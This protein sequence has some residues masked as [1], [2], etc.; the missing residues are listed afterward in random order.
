MHVS[1][2]TAMLRRR[3]TH[4]LY[5]NPW[6]PSVNHHLDENGKVTRLRPRRD[7][8][9]CGRSVVLRSTV[10]VASRRFQEKLHVTS[11][12]TVYELN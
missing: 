10:K 8:S 1:T 12:E 5:F 6:Q 4:L 11:T 7:I 9:I 3:L 2:H